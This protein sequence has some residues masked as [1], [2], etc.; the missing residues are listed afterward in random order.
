MNT[1]PSPAPAPELQRL[2][3]LLPFHALGTLTGDDRDFVEAWLAQHAAS[4][5]GLLAEI[6]WL[7]LSAEQA[8]ALAHE[9]QAEAGLGELMARIAAER[10][11]P[12]RTSS[13][14]PGWLRR[15][16]EWW[17]LR[18]ALGTALAAVVLVQALVIGSL[19]QRDGAEQVP[20]SGGATHPVAGSVVFS[21]AFKPGATEA[22]MRTWLQRERLQLVG[23]PSALG[24]WRVAVPKDR[25]DAALAM[26]QAANP[27]VESVQREP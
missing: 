6:A 3:E 18:P 14:A 11:A 4:Q 8:R 21:I 26:L 20:L 12:V 9:P 16:A 22:D 13:T 25:A 24:L 10:P 17:S 23:G 19:I 27:L 2:H 7:R 1:P 15:L 5:P